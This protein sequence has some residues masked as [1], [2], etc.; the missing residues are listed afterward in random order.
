MIN[1]L[2]IT[3]SYNYMG[4]I[5]IHGLRPRLKVRLMKMPITIISAFV[6]LISLSTT[7]YASA[8]ASY[9]A[10]YDV[11]LA[12]GHNNGN[13]VGISGRIV[14][15]FQKICGGWVLQQESAMELQLAEGGSVPDYTAFS[16]WEADD[17]SRY[18]YSLSRNKDPEQT[19]LGDAKMIPGGGVASFQK[20][21]SVQFNL[22]KGVLFPVAHTK[23]MI[24][25]AEKGETQFNAI[26]FEGTE[27]EG[28]KM[29]SAFVSKLAPANDKYSNDV[30][31]GELAD[32]PGW[33]VHIAY[34]DPDALTPEPIYEIE[35]DLLDNGIAKRWLL[36]YGS[37]GAE[38]ILKKVEAIP[39]SDC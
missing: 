27:V 36:G 7:A 4:N 35:V 18:R 39:A 11:R 23:E 29:I 34:F 6:V 17:G 21:K 14:Y 8:L 2:I 9:R 33:M 31:L 3:N 12:E 13:I 15:N 20:P 25:R 30:S 1:E 28:A 19:I 16:S 24:A 32:R 26:T 22:P 38:M 10:I 37:L 5:R